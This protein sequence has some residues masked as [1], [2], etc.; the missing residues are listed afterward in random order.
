MFKN[1]W[2]VKGRLNNVKKKPDDLVLWDVPKSP[3]KNLHSLKCKLILDV[4]FV[5]WMGCGRRRCEQ[6]PELEGKVATPWT[7][8][9][10]STTQCCSHRLKLIITWFFIYRV[11][12]IKSNKR[13]PDCE[14]PL[15]T[16]TLSTDTGVKPINTFTVSG[17]TWVEYLLL[18]NLN[19]SPH[20]L[21]KWLT[22]IITSIFLTTEESA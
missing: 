18:F 9:Q 15:W 3:Y 14:Y 10:V 4:N 22:L 6:K 11:T 12:D 21:F 7:L 5:A 1:D 2:G 13:T 20:H 19:I 8:E 17:D 16:M